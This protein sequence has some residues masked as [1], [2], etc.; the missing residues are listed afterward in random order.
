MSLLFTFCIDDMRIYDGLSV[1][2]ANRREIYNMCEIFKNVYQ[3]SVVII[4]Y[5]VHRLSLREFSLH[6]HLS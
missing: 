5:L 4:V 2:S 6:D 1:A 3:N